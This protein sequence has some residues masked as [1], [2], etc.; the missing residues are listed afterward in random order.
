MSDNDV[1]TNRV[2]IS[3]RELE[4]RLSVVSQTLDRFEAALRQATNQTNSSTTS[5]MVDGNALSSWL[6]V[7]VNHRRFERLI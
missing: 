3:E 6:Q 7:S 4:A 5:R 2:T 1:A